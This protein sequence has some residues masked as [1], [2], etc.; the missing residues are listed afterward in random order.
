[1]NSEQL[2]MDKDL[3]QEALQNV[4]EKSKVPTILHMQV[5]KLLTSKMAE[6]KKDREWWVNFI[7]NHEHVIDDHNKRNAYHDIQSKEYTNQIERLKTLA[8]GEKGDQGEKG[9]TPVKGIHYFD[10]KDADEEKIISQVLQKIPIPKNGQKGKDADEDK[11]VSVIISRIQKENL[12]DLSHIKGAQGFIK[13]G[14]KYKFE[15]LMHGSK[16][17]GGSA[18]IFTQ[19]PTGTIDGVNKT[20]TTAHT[21]TTVIGLWYNGEFVHPSEY[22]VSGSGFTMGTALPAFSPAGSFTISYT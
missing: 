4:L 8:K 3:V 18:T 20:Y 22:T 21:I 14:V 16:S 5:I 2:S 17:S 19:T 12:I 11:I 9:E 13:D 10:G 15:E 6:H 1:M 7:Q